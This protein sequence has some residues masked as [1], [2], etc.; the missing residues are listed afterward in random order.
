MS[1]QKMDMQNCNLIMTRFNRYGGELSTALSW[2][3]QSITSGLGT[4]WQ[5]RS[6]GDFIE[7]YNRISAGLGKEL[8][9]FGKLTAKLEKAIIAYGE[10]DEKFG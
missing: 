1:D 7:E 8:E 2:L 10:V 6:A 9:E 5:G 3:T 4:A